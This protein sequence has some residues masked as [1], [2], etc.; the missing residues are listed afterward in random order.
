MVIFSAG[1]VTIPGVPGASTMT[2]WINHVNFMGMCTPI[3]A[4]AGIAIG[5]DIKVFKKLGWRIVVVG[6]S[7]LSGT[8]I[9]S[10]FIAECVL[11][12]MA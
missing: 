7:V 1:I 12:L 9:G 3:L 4:Y 11:R 10:A 8:F 5:K 2:Q 6:L